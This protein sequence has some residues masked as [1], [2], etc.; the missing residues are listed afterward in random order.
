LLGSLPLATFISPSAGG[1]Y[2][3]RP[4]VQQAAQVD[5][6]ANVVQSQFDKLHPLFHKVLVF[7]L[8]HAVSA[9]TDTYTDHGV[10]RLELTVSQQSVG[11]LEQ[12][13]FD[14]D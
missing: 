2:G 8:H 4:I 6:I 9:A 10:Q 1:D 12:I 11:T 13:I 3:A 5:A 14:F 7:G